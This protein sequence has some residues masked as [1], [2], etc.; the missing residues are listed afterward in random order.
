MNLIFILEIALLINLVAPRR[1][2]PP[3]PQH[4]GKFHMSSQAEV[5]MYQYNGSI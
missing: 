1:Y 2:V 5:G 4:E 3:Q